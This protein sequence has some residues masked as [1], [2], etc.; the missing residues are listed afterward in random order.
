MQ[1][2]VEIQAVLDRVKA[3]ETLSESD[4]LE[5]LD[6]LER[7]GEYTAAQ[8]AQL[9]GVTDRQIRRDR[10][11]LRE[12]YQQAM[13]DLNVVGEL[14]RQFEI[15]LSRMDQAIADGDYQRVRSL[16]MRWGVCE[17]FARLA[18]NFQLDEL[19]KLIE[20]MRARANVVANVN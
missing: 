7:S 3:G 18:F 4:R 2:P 5:A 9:L 6:A 19:S 13:R 8:L 14:Y 1:I 20:T 16:A 10:A 11:K 15:T 12:R 17:S